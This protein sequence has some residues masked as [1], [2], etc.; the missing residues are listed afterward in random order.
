MNL[1]QIKD[2]LEVLVPEFPHTTYST[3]V[4][5]WLNIAQNEIAAKKLIEG[6]KTAT[7]TASTSEYTFTGIVDIKRNGLSHDSATLTPVTEQ[8]LDGLYDEWRS[9]DPG[10]PLYYLP[11]TSGAIL[12]PSPDTTGKTI[13]AKGYYQPDDMSVDA[14][15]PFEVDDVRAQNTYDLEPLLIEYGIGMMKFSLGFYDTTQSALSNF[16]SMLSGKVTD[17]TAKKV[18]ERGRP[19]IDSFHLRNL[20]RRISG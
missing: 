17:K 15:D 4:T 12:I 9:L 8:E 14:D 5:D 10:T 6:T 20:Q 16:Y 3:Q 7:S 11:T 18:N 13:E 19:N 2:S 1:G